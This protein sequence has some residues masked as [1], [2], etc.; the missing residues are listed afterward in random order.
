MATKNNPPKDVSLGSIKAI[1]LENDTEAGTRH[2][3]TFSRLHRDGEAGSPPLA[4]ETLNQSR[5]RL[6]D[7]TGLVDLHFAY[8]A[9]ISE[10]TSRHSDL[11]KKLELNRFDT[12][13]VSDN[14][15]S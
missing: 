3:V 4:K 12:T 6:V 11:T 1:L 14:Y 15:F 9:R 7:F 10:L 13:A 5:K 2:N 8:A